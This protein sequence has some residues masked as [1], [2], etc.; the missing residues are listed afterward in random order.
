MFPTDTV[1]RTF[2]K[3][4]QE[5]ASKS[6]SSHPSWHY[7][8]LASS[9]AP[10]SGI[11]DWNPCTVLHLSQPLGFFVSQLASV[12]AGNW[13]L[14]FKVKWNQ[15]EYAVKW[16]QLVKRNWFCKFD[17][18]RSMEHFCIQIM[19]WRCSRLCCVVTCNQDGLCLQHVF[20][21]IAGEPNETKECLVWMVLPHM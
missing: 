6:G 4:W 12:H 9:F 21:K 14:K 8:V 3:V 13:R 17:R 16:D 20:G 18:R 5:S 10:M 1:P 19:L 2:P 15:R 11:L 7:M